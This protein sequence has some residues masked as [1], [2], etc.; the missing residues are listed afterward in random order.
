MIG[1]AL[2]KIFG[3]KSDRDIKLIMPY[4]EKTNE[5]YAKLQAINDDELRAKTDSVKEHIDDHLKDID[6]VKAAK[7]VINRK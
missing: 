4:V 3:T 2:K 1:K 6:I 5:E 7:K